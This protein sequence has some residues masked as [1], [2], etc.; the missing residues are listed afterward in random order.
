MRA[1]TIKRQKPRIARCLRDGTQA[2][3]VPRA[4]RNQCREP[5]ECGIPIYTSINIRSI[6]LFWFFFF[7]AG[8][9]V[10]QFPHIFR[11][12]ISQCTIPPLFIGVIIPKLMFGITAKFFDSAGVSLTY[13]LSEDFDYIRVK[14]FSGLLQNFHDRRLFIHFI[15]VCIL[16][17]HRVVRIHDR[18]DA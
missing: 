17:G 9:F 16:A 5:P 15:S 13:F 18:Y 3:A 4:G 12:F 14:L 8:R 11:I 6:D 10:F 1:L 2:A 7:F